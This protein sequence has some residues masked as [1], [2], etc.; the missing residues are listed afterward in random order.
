MNK[1]TLLLFISALATGCANND[2]MATDSMMTSDDK[3]DS[4]DGDSMKPM[5]SDNM[6]MDE[7]MEKP[8]MTKESM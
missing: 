6:K 8:V 5:A 7:P 2:T 3:M 1:L 4:M